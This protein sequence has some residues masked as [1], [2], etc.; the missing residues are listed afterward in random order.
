MM[1]T[2]STKKTTLIQLMKWNTQST[3]VEKFEAPSGIQNSVDLMLV[4]STG[5]LVEAEAAGPAAVCARK[6]VMEL[7]TVI[8]LVS[9]P[10]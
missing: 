1:A 4:G 2:T 3:S 10:R 6:E 9:S 5:A 8:R 7:S